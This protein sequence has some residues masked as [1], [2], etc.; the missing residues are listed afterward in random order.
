MLGDTLVSRTA[1]H[2]EKSFR[3]LIKFNP[4]SDCSYHFPI[5][6]DQTERPFGSKSIGKWQLQ[7]DLSWI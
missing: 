7:S 6:L 3:N 5:D 4:E 1:I 2:T